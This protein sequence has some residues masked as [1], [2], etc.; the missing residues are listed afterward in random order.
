[1]KLIDLLVQRDGAITSA[2]LAEKSGGEE[3]LISTFNLS[4][5]VA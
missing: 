5:T 1:M 2:E 4:P 3:L